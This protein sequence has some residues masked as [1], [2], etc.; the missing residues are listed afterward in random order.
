VGTPYSPTT[1]WNVFTYSTP[2]T[3]LQPSVF[4]FEMGGAC[5]MF[6][7]EETGMQIFFILYNDKKIHN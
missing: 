5:R 1:L 7:S 6:E 3:D 2:V 4:Q